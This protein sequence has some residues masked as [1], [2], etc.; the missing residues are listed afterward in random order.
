MDLNT[1]HL[2]IS[3]KNSIEGICGDSYLQIYLSL[4]SL[5]INTTIHKCNKNYFYIK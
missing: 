5:N 4:C 3:K 1:F 2:R